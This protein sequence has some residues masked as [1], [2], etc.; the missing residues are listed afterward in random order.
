[1]SPR[2]SVLAAVFTMHTSAG[3]L[4]GVKALGHATCTMDVTSCRQINRHVQRGFHNL[5]KQLPLI[6]QVKM[7]EIKTRRQVWIKEIHCMNVNH[8]RTRYSKHLILTN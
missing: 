5:W 2:A 7:T 3:K 4:W 6:L 1:M 8:D